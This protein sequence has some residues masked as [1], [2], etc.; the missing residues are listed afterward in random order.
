MKQSKE[1]PQDKGKK[2]KLK[3]LFFP[4]LSMYVGVIVVLNFRI[5]LFT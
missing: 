1:N 5:H 4:G 3:G 2:K